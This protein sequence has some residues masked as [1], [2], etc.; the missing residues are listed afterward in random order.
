MFPQTLLTE[1]E[2]AKVQ[3]RLE[4]SFSMLDVYSEVERHT[5]TRLKSAR[6]GKQATGA[7]PYDDCSGDDDGFIVWPE[8][9]DKRKHYMCRNCKR[10][11]HILKLVMDVGGLKFTPACEALGI[12]NPY[13]DCNQLVGVAH[14]PVKRESVV[15]TWSKEELEYLTTLYSRM[16]IALTSDRARAYLE[17]RAIPL[18]VAQALGMGYVPALSRVA[19]VTPPL[20]KFSKWCDRIIFPL[21][22]PDGKRGF[23]GRSLY[24]WT[25]S[26]DETEH[27]ILLDAQKE[28]R[29]WEKT[30]PAGFF[31]WQMGTTGDSVTICEG[32]FDAAAIYAAGIRN[33]VA[34]SGT[35]IDAASVP[36]HVET[37]ILA[38][39]ADAPG[40]SSAKKLA[41]DL[42]RKGLDVRECVP[43]QGK[44]W[45]EAYRLHGA[46]GL[47]ALQDA[48]G[49]VCNPVPPT[50]HDLVIPEVEPILEPDLETMEEEIETS[51]FI[52]G[53]DVDRYSSGG[54]A[55]CDAHYTQMQNFSPGSIA[56]IFDADLGER[57]L[58]G[59]SSDA[60][61]DRLRAADAVKP[62]VNKPDFWARNKA[63]ILAQEDRMRKNGYKDLRSFYERVKDPVPA[64]LTPHLRGVTA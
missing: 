34:L 57:S 35:S 43:G 27:K 18:D 52:C 47:Q 32:P 58:P 13:K 20:Q 15:D 22:A 1:E 5:S 33:V 55:Y 4:M 38:L 26:M 45:S 48:V 2:K 46:S 40:Q 50:D 60:F 30:Y 8:L 7:C 61:I 36:I 6:S 29:R 10:A 12:P 31:G 59:E 56:Q 19:K 25:P 14:K 54:H 42:K 17:Q 24:M 41:K 44:D 49:R 37:V 16:Q 28:V 39:D 9:T 11:G 51:C 3:E 23:I 53:A 64:H 21:Q 62:P 63:R